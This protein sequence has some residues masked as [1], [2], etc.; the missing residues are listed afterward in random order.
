MKII[1]ANRI[2]PDW[3]PRFAASHLGPFCLSM[4]HKKDDM[5]IVQIVLIVQIIFYF[6]PFEFIE[7]ILRTQ[8]LSYV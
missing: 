2:S 4:P 6:W 1:L 5:L 7:Y 8:K 3:T